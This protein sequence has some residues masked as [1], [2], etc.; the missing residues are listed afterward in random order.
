MSVPTD[1]AASF[2]PVY[3]Y[4]PENPEELRIQL[5]NQLQ[6]HAEAINQRDI[7]SYYEYEQLTGQQF[8]D[9]TNNDFQSVW[10]KVINTGT[11]PNATTSSTAHGITITGSNT[12]FTRIYGVATDPGTGAIPL[13]YV[14]VTTLGDGIQV[15]VDA[16]NVV[17]TTGKNWSAYTSSYVVLEYIIL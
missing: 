15:D 3:S 5:I 7:A 8:Q 2:V 6:T 4:L 13:P 1:Y 17:L 12:I 14:D 16:T 11:L 10:R 9:T